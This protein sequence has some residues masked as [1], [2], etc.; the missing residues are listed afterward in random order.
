MQVLFQTVPQAFLTSHFCHHILPAYYH[1][2]SVSS[3]AS[4][5]TFR[6]EYA[7]LP[8]PSTWRPNRHLNF[9]KAPNSLISY[10][11]APWLFQPSSGCKSMIN[12]TVNFNPRW[13]L[14]PPFLLY[15]HWNHFGMGALMLIHFLSDPFIILL[16]HSV[17]QSKFLWLLYLMEG[18]WGWEDGRRTM[19]EGVAL[20]LSVLSY[21]SFVTSSP[22]NRF[23]VIPVSMGCLRTLETL[24][25]FFVLLA[26]VW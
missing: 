24:A 11:R 16:L 13:F 1:P 22:T 6:D 21:I 4:L 26:W 9:N 14:T 20:S 8:G 3:L 18:D 23:S 15:P 5:L 12:T 17:F 10:R 2:F 19:R 7:C 25:L